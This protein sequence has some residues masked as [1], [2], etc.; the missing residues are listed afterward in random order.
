MFEKEKR[1][2]LRPGNWAIGLFWV[3]F[4][5]LIL[6]NI[7]RWATINVFLW[8]P[9][10]FV[11]WGA[12]LK[13]GR[14][15]CLLYSLAIILYNWLAFRAAA[16]GG[17]TLVEVLFYFVG[18]GFAAI[19]LIWKQ[20]QFPGSDL[21]FRYFRD[22]LELAAKP[23]VG[24]NDGYTGRPFP[25]GHTRYTKKEILSFSKFLNKHFIA[26]S[27]S[28][29]TGVKLVFSNGLF[30]YIPFWKPNWQKVTHMSFDFN[31]SIS[32][33]I[34]RKHYR[35][36]MVEI[37][38]DQ[39]CSSIGNVITGLMED[40]QKGDTFKILNTVRGREILTQEDLEKRGSYLSGWLGDIR[41]NRLRR[42]GLLNEK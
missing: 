37:T 9:V 24:M 33:F 27:Y 39:L 13:T 21:P 12:F 30:Q 23:V 42:K 38:F 25:A 1:S 8:I 2:N 19:Y 41:E 14:M 6:L 7:T 20:W 17:N 4:Y 18:F 28:D 36:Y 15:E 5:G 16:N 35:Q 29:D 26:T 34:A 22:L 3:F 32:I 10:W 40:F 11:F 31:G